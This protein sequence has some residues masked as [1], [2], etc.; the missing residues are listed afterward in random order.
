MFILT[1]AHPHEEEEALISYCSHPHDTPSP[2]RHHAGLGSCAGVGLAVQFQV[3]RFKI[4]MKIILLLL[5]SVFFY[6]E[7][8]IIKFVLSLIC[9]NKFVPQ[10]SRGTNVQGYYEAEIYYY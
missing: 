2:C 5:Y 6:M 8:V 4:W 7:F 9:K 10:S 1:H 3:Y